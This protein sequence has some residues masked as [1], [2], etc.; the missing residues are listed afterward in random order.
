MKACL[1][2]CVLFPTV[3]RELLLGVAEKGV[4]SPVWSDR[5]LGEWRHAAARRLGADAGVE[6]ENA[7]FWLRQNWPC[8]SVTV[9]PELTDTLWLPDMADVH[10][11]AAAI[12][13][14]AEVIV[15]FNLRDFPPNIL[16]EHKISRAGPDEFLM[17]IA[18]A[19]PEI[20]GAVAKAVLDRANVMSGDQFDMRRLLK[21]ARL[22]R[23]AKALTKD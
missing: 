10:V 19:Q 7:S 8:A 1:D 21:K 13:G 2:A 6:A 16:A 15:T 5:I 4:F 14:E 18:Q 23:L 12:L 3:L 22:P 11:L 9:P 20:M 17:G